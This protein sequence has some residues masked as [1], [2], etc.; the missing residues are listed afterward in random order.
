MT[1][2]QEAL[3]YNKRLQLLKQHGMPGIFLVSPVFLSSLSLVWQNNEVTKEVPYTD[4][5]LYLSEAVT[6]P[7]KCSSM[8]FFPIV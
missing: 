5:S 8:Y 3:G 1:K 2:I 7:F 6:L 4:S